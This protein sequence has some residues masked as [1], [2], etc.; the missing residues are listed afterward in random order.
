MTANAAQKDALA[1]SETKPAAASSLPEKASADEYAGPVS[2]IMR[3]QAHKA[4][5]TGGKP[6]VLSLGLVAPD[7]G[8]SAAADLF[9]AREWE[10]VAKACA[11]LLEIAP[12]VGA[13]D[14]NASGDLVTRDI[15]ALIQSVSAFEPV[16]EV[17][18]MFALQAAAMHHVTMRSLALASRSSA[19][20]ESKAFNLGQANKASRTFTALVETLNRHRGKTTTQ[21]VIVENVTVEAG[22]QAVVGAVEGAGARSRRGVQPHAETDA[23]SV[24]GAPMRSE[25]AKRAPLRIASSEGQEALPDARRREGERRAARQPKPGDARPLSGGSDSGTAAVA[26][27]DR[28]SAADGARVKGGAA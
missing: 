27:A 12:P 11:E 21:R 6:A 1:L 20:T 9:G 18:G 14:P 25:N 4:P 5:S 24:A 19:T 10:F 22:G 8:G 28:A 7:A 2:R 13:D 16:D 23:G 26:N 17:E 15:N 3:A